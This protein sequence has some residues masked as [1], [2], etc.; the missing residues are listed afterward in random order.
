VTT[1]AFMCCLLFL[2]ADRM[3]D[4]TVVSVCAESAAG[5]LSNDGVELSCRRA[6]GWGAG[7]GWR[8]GGVGFQ[9]A[10]RG[11]CGFRAAMR[12]ITAATRAR[13]P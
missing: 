7:S 9:P 2:T 13:A 10:W 6:P 3:V 5:A 12:V 4:L 8:F 1:I 11:K